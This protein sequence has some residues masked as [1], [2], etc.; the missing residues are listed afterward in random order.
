[1]T[2][3]ARAGAMKP[4]LYALLGAYSLVVVLPFFWMFAASFKTTREIFAD[5]FGW[6]DAPSLDNYAR[7][8]EQGIGGYFL[9]SLLVTVATVVLII[10]LSGIAAYGFARLKFRGRALLYTLIIAGYAVP[11][12]TVLVPLY[13]MLDAAGMLDSYAG[14]VL[15]YVAF[16]IPFSIILLYAFLL[17]FPKELEEAAR[18]DGCNRWQTI[19]HVVA[20]LSLPGLSS[21]AIFSGVFTWNEFLLGL[22]I[23]SSDGL[24]TLPVGLVA[25]QGAYASDWGAL[26]AGVVLATVP[27]LVL[28]MVMQKHFVRSLAGLGK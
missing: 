15:P 14:L 27:L 7:A 1:M 10:G 5:P 13:E 18:L 25:F 4:L 23:L 17:E 22:L 24:K 26:M 8:W 2:G 20:P 6:P 9:N 19:R 3:L 12:H 21:V 16:G 28:Y 11:I